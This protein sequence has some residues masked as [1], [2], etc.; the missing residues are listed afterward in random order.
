MLGVQTLLN[1]SEKGH[2]MY[3]MVKPTISLYPSITLYVAVTNL[4]RKRAIS[5]TSWV[6]AL[7]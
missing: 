4:N 5:M 2:G 7:C 3:I 1:A 6:C